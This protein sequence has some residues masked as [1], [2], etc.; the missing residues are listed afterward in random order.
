MKVLQSSN[1]RLEMADDYIGRGATSHV[2]EAKDVDTM[3]R[4][5]VKCMGNH[6]NAAWSEISAFEQIG[7]HPNIVS[8][9]GFLRSTR[10]MYIVMELATPLTDYVAR[11]PGGHM[12]E[13]D[14]SLVLAD[15][16]F[17]LQHCHKQG[18]AHRDLKAENI[19]ISTGGRGMLADFGLAESTLLKAGGARFFRGCGS[20][21]YCAPCVLRGHCKDVKA[22]D[23]WSLGV[24]TYW[25]LTSRLPFESPGGS[26]SELHQ[27]IQSGCYRLL[28]SALSPAAKDFVH[29]MLQV[30]PQA[31]P[32]LEQLLQH[33]FISTALGKKQQSAEAWSRK[34]WRRRRER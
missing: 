30:D 24:L 22:A 3:E 11:L 33:E 6:N 29:S 4:Y 14:A 10:R 26:A 32:Q 17:G 18:I 13:M 28:P 15:L 34:R 12:S 9:K 20:P 27:E 16:I 23:V 8:F 19:L 7:A 21:A 2:R 1:F 31:R 25:M 5:A